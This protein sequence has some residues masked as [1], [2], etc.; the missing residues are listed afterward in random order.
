MKKEQA[1]EKYIKG[2][3]RDHKEYLGCE[4]IRRMTLIQSDMYTVRQT[5]EDGW[6]EAKKQLVE[7]VKKSLDE[8]NNQLFCCRHFII[9]DTEEFIKSI[10]EL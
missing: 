5:F 1:S 6:D 4:E 2:K 8:L 9:V 3:L 7:N 10:I